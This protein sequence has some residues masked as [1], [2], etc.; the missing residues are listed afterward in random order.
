MEELKK[1]FKEIG[2]TEEE[3]NE[4]INEHGIKELKLETLLENVKRNYSFFLSIGYSK[5][6]IIK[7]TKTLPQ[8]YGL[9][10]DN[11]KQKIEDIEKLGYS[12]EE[13]IKMTKSLPQIYGLSIYTIKQ[14]IEDI[15][16]LG[17][18]KEDV[19]KMTK[20]SPTI[21]GLSIDN[22]KQKIEDMEKL[23]YS[24][25]E[26][27]K[28][29][30]TLPAI[31]CLSIDNMKQK[32]EDMEKLGYNREEVIK[33]TKTLPQIYS[34]SIDNIK[35]K[36]E[37]YDSIGLHSLAIIDAKQLMQSTNLSYARYMYYKDIGINI[38]ETNYRK[39]FIGQ[40]KF[41]Q[42]YGITKEELL[43]KYDYQEYMRKK[44]T[45]DLGK[46]VVDVL[47]NTEYLGDTE[48]TICAHEK[49]EK[50]VREDETRQSSENQSK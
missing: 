50:S 10:I 16:K 47:E 33:M 2:Y 25:E 30:K 37:F 23:G 27:I 22:I 4:I 36:I 24:Q 32:I 40:K 46:E 26:V 29:T 44:N 42:Q 28:M 7:M 45:Q 19:I 1:I 35:Q 41:K 31:Y 12:K 3:M 6:D 13:V 49:N 9:S 48:E 17:Y 34:Y 15:E 43:A 14:K 21:Y 38:D 11:I 5:E 39:L 18:S 20:N 8:I